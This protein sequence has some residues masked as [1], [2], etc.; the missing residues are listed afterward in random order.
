[1]QD[2]NSI[3]ANFNPL[4]REDQIYKNWEA[5][6]Y[7][8]A[9][10]D[11]SK[12]PYT[13]MMPPPNITGQLHMGH[14]LDSTLQDILI[15]WRRMQGYSALWLPGTDHASI[16]TEAKVVDQIRSEGLQK[17]EIGREGFLERSWAWKEKYGST[18]S[19]QLRKMGASCDWE[20]ER[21]T[22][23]KGLSD[24]V[25]TV[26]VDLYNKGLIYRGKRMVN[27]CPD[28]N[29]SI[30]DIE[31]VFKDQASH[32]W[33]LDY[34]LEDGSGVLS[35]ATTRPE[36]MLGDTAVAVHP[37]D[38]RYTE[39]VG[40]YL[41]LPLVGRR[42]PI[43]ADDY[44]SR[45]FG[46]GCVKITPA[47]DPNDFQMGERHGLEF[48]EVMDEHGI[49]NEQAGTYAGLTREACRVKIVADLEAAG[50]LHHIEPYSHSVG[51][52]Q[53]CGTTVEPR[54]SLQ[55]F[56][57]MEP[58]A[59]PAI[60]VVEEGEIRFVPAHF[61]KTYFNWMQN[62]RDWCIS[63]QLWWGHRI[64]AWYCENEACG[65]VHVAKAA[66]ETCE[67][68][69]GTAFR[70]DEDTLDTWFSSALWPFSTLG[71]PEHTPDFE[72]FYPTDVLVTGYD[73]IFFW[74]ARMIF[75]AI[76]QTGRIPFHTVSIHGM[77][78]DSLGRKMSKS[79]NN[80]VDPLDIIAKYGA[81][82]LR[83]ALVT[84]TAPGNDQ[85]YQEEVLDAGRAFSNK[86]WNAFRFVLM[87]L[88]EDEPE[89]DVQQLQ[90]E[91]R[92]ILS[93]VNTVI[94]D[95]TK[96][97]EGFELGVA[98]ARIY[99]FIW[100]EFCDWYIEMAKPRLFDKT[101]A[102][103]TT[104]QAILLQVLRQSMQLLHPFMPFLTE[105]VYQYLP[106]SAESIMI[107]TWP[108]AKPEL[109]DVNAEKNM[110]VLFDATRQI[111][112]LRMEMQVSPK[113]RIQA[114]VLSEDR[115]VRAHFVTAAAYL[116]RLAGV[117]TLEVA[118]TGTEVDTSALTVVFSRGTIYIPMEDMVDLAKERERLRE[119]EG[120]LL[121]DLAHS[122]KTLGSP[123]FTDRAPA[124]VVQKERDKR[125]DIENRLKATRERLAA[126]GEAAAAK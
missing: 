115:E 94:D 12:R 93:R 73:I 38:P 76:E 72:Y 40:K 81:D 69:G 90:L 83:Y 102:G 54:A 79:L 65:H 96:S 49:M 28:C 10:T 21:F 98:L 9:E 110:S 26:F 23:D 114:L 105:E 92:W 103:R 47:H 75:S 88:D 22:L 126:L 86:I 37:D 25:E 85:R 2:K 29:T 62:I 6:G 101:H 95:V 45:E 56:V 82:A 80:G 35:V 33:H 68:C 57:K 11:P 61:E 55:W 24:A 32:L 121:S 120:K 1:M 124:A 42:I 4:D 89:I 5:K 7:F 91:D 111:R 116:E 13:I 41:V 122:D 106:Q 107:S 53:R 59:K 19:R 104:A 60:D 15:R 67:N 112:Q 78:R 66:P 71:W 119:E 50:A 39:L 125:A 14:A 113:K 27:W 31:V 108:E 52:C 100:E 97:L 117:G 64:P 74:V 77:V 34:P 118:E 43:I 20:R 63:R 17:E 36:T 30:S 99:S 58:L 18:I 44:V 16:A 8:H 109:I 87:N 3:P 46:T 48:I 70:Q 51:T 84:G 123:G